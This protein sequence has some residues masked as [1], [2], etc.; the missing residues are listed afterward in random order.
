[1]AAPTLPTL[2]PFKEEAQGVLVPVVELLDVPKFTVVGGIH[3]E[4][5]HIWTGGGQF[6]TQ[7]KRCDR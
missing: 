1:M 4:T 2:P 6:E 3:D 5:T 7:V